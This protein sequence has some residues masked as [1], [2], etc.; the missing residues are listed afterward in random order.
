[1]TVNTAV[2]AQYCTAEHTSPSIEHRLNGKIRYS[3]P[4]ELVDE[5]VVPL[6]VRLAV[7]LRSAVH[8]GLF[9]IDPPASLEH[10]TSENVD[11]VEYGRCCL[12]CH[13]LGFWEE[14]E[15]DDEVEREDPQVY[16]V[17]ER[18]PGLMSMCFRKFEE[19]KLTISSR[20][21]LAQ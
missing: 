7:V 21:F 17:A 4:L 19:P 2:Q 5:E 1:L 13:L 12:R 11:L 16:T 15:D 18:D 20:S 14:Q 3:A 10:A 6:D 9:S 8:N